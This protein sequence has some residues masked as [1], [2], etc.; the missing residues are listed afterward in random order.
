MQGMGFPQMPG[1]PMPGMPGQPGMEHLANQRCPFYDTQGICYL[2]TACP[3][4]HGDA[5]GKNDGKSSSLYP[6]EYWANMFD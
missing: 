4:K 2:G 5:G 3:Y 6:S 1:M